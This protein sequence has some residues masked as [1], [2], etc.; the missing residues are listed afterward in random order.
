MFRWNYGD[1]G[2][3]KIAKEYGVSYTSFIG[4]K[5]LFARIHQHLSD[6]GRDRDLIAW[7]IFRVYRSVIMKGE[8]GGK[9]D[10]PSNQLVS[11][12]VDE[13]YDE[14]VI[15]SIRRYQG[16]DLSWFGEWHD[17]SGM[18]HEGGSKNTI[19]FKAVYKVLKHKF[20]ADIEAI[21]IVELKV[22]NEDVERVAE[23]RRESNKES[24]HGCFA[25]LF[26][27]IGFSLLLFEFVSQVV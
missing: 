25:S 19:A 18:H 12:I 27:F 16:E 24:N 2:S 22:D 14:K 15:K 17:P 3:F 23:I 7:F 6:E 9:I 26:V 10:S 4:K 11:N 8:A 13:I 20:G 5:D 21:K 1:T